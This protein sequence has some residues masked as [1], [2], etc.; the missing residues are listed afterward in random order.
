MLRPTFDSVSSGEDEEEAYSLQFNLSRITPLE[1]DCL[2][3]SLDSSI[4]KLEE[5]LL[6][7]ASSGASV[8]DLAKEICTM[9][10]RRSQLVDRLIAC[11]QKRSRTSHVDEDVDDE[12][13]SCSTPQGS[14]ESVSLVQLPETTSP[15]PPTRCNT[16][17]SKDQRIKP[18]L[19]PLQWQPCMWTAVYHDF[20][21]L[22]DLKPP[23]SP[24]GALSAGSYAQAANIGEVA[25][26]LLTQGFPLLGEGSFT[27][28]FLLTDDWVAKVTSTEPYAYRRFRHFQERNRDLA[29]W[30]AY[31]TCFA[32]T[33]AVYVAD[34]SGRL[35]RIHI[36]ERLYPPF[37]NSGIDADLLKNQ[38]HAFD[39]QE[40]CRNNPDPKSNRSLLKQWAYTRDRRLVCFDYQ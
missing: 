6:V 31:P 29:M 27:L 12:V 36:Q 8:A 10:S 13:F 19:D 25:R 30:A 34:Q 18:V 38:P 9:K 24:P 1:A 15:S 40:A 20:M 17:S 21:N 7:D 35:H 28:T 2:I 23:L 4:R 33:R 22:W 11:P 37:I 16:R 3:R 39:I 26:Y 14:Q 32:K 5:R